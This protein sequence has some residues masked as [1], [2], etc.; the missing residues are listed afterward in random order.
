MIIDPSSSVSLHALAHSQIHEEAWR[1]RKDFMLGCKVLAKIPLRNL[2]NLAVWI[3]FLKQR[4]EL[5]SIELD[6]EI[7]MLKRRKLQFWHKITSLG[8]YCLVF[9]IGIKC[10]WFL[11]S[12]W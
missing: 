10:V 8:I 11:N 7:D 4:L 5:A 1:F 3:P 12:R 2:E 6:I 9:R